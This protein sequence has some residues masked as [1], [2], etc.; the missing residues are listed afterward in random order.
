MRIGILGSTEL[1]TDDGE[2]LPSGGSGRRALLARLAVEAGRVVPVGRLLDDVYDTGAPAYAANAL[3][4]QISRIRATLRSVDGGHL[5]ESHPGGYRLA[6]A[7]ED[8]DALLF[9]RLAASGQRALTNGDPHT[10]A[11]VLDEALSLWRGE[12]LSDVG[13][14]P[15]VSARRQGLDETRLTAME[16]RYAAR[17]AIGDPS[18]LITPLKSLLAEHPSRERLRG[19]TM[20]ALASVG[21]QAEA[22]ALFE[23]GRAWLADELGA[24]PSAEL[25]EAHLEV[26]RGAASAPAPSPHVPSPATGGPKLPRPAPTPITRFVGGVTELDDL[27]E[28]LKTERLVT[29]VGPSGVGKTRRALEVATRVTGAVCVAEFA[30]A[31]TDAEVVQVVVNA[32]DIRAGGLSASA[33]GAVEEPDDPTS[34]LVAALSDTATLLVFDNCEHVLPHVASLAH[35]L[36]TS[37]PALRVLATSQEHLGVT[38]EVLRPVSPLALPDVGSPAEAAA[39]SPAVRLFAERA[40]AVRPGFQVD[41]TTVGDV[42]TICRTLDGLPLA[43]ELAAARL[44]AL[45]LSTVTERLADRFDVLTRGNRVAHPKHRTLR[46]AVSWSWDLLDDEEQRLARRFSVFSGGAT[47]DAVEATCGGSD[48]ADTL[49]D[50]VD[51][52]FLQVSGHR[53]RMLETIRTY[54]TERLAEAEETRDVRSAH[55]AHFLALSIEAE[56]HLRGADQATW[57]RTL[58]PEQENLHAALRWSVEHDTATALR[59]IAA[60]TLHMWM[61]GQ[62]HEWNA[63][64]ATLLRKVGGTPPTGLEEEYVLCALNAMAA[65]PGAPD[66]A[67]GTLDRVADVVLSLTGPRHWPILTLL[68]PTFYGGSQGEVPHLWRFVDA[69]RSSDEPWT[70]A[71]AQ[72]VRGYIHMHIAEPARAEPDLREG[73]DRLRALGDT[74]GQIQGLAGLAGLYSGRGD[75]ER[76]LVL[77]SEA[78]RLAEE[79]DAIEDSGELA[80][81]RGDAL[82]RLGRLEESDREYERAAVFGRRAGSREVMVWARTGSARVARLRG[83]LAKA[84]RLC[85]LARDVATEGSVG[86]PAW[87]RQFRV[88]IERYRIAESEHGPRSAARRHAVALANPQSAPHLLAC[89]G[90]GEVIASALAAAGEPERAAIVLG[91]TVATRGATDVIDADGRTTVKTLRAA[92]GDEAFTVAFTTGVTTPRADLFPTVAAAV[93]TLR[94]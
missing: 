77:T 17:L 27:V 93:E 94:G 69:C 57:L 39:A 49:A 19:L 12:A 28:L 63:L 9:Q 14:A 90:A 35:T 56:R 91:I 74:W 45:S 50:L 92:L 60:A 89:V 70:S 79:I 86:G 36:L 76:T 33:G 62:R 29:L 21:R 52:S 71:T 47:L 42:V 15:F 32:M 66:L 68:W 5:L 54:A 65:G 67:E 31:R 88:L 82:E 20:R 13:E 53:F 46:A 48:V 40:R 10:A 2:V 8:V 61:R 59:L 11:P 51:K 30:D 4:S 85:D 18:D 22:L 25:S 83:D 78:L 64:G 73:T 44:R 87:R 84:R 43:I 34:R 75:A 24:D 38:G 55:A 37:C 72:V 81:M 7:P 6:V 58:S 16:S 26:L 3:Q 1:W 23:E 80:C 41:D